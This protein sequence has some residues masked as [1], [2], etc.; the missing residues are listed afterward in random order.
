MK[1]T[2]WHLRTVSQDHLGRFGLERE[3]RVSML[4]S[5]AIP[6]QTRTSAVNDVVSYEI[7]LLYRVPVLTS[8]LATKV[9]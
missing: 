5:D 4:T 9:S 3:E 7:I 2:D 6:S 1:A 8:A